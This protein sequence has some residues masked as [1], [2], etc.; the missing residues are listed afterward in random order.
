MNKNTKRRQ[1]A[2]NKENRGNFGKPV[3]KEKVAP[4][5]KPNKGEKED[6]RVSLAHQRHIFNRTPCECAVA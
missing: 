4:F 1:A 3:F 5:P 2:Y 6:M